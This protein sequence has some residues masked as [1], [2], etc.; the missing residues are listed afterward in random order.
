MGKGSRNRTSRSG[1]VG[2]AGSLWRAAWAYAEVMR[3]LVDQYHP[4][5]MLSPDRTELPGVLITAAITKIADI[6]G[7]TAVTQ[8]RDLADVPII[9][10]ETLLGDYGQLDLLVHISSIGDPRALPAA[11][12]PGDEAWTMLRATMDDLNSGGARAA[13]HDPGHEARIR[14]YNEHTWDP[15]RATAREIILF[16]L[17]YTDG[18]TSQTPAVLGL[19]ARQAAAGM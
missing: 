9:K 11:G 16:A 7:L 2:A 1:E 14:E 10:I 18:V 6:H 19:W 12:D 5:D 15:A 4:Q 8:P 17:T 3:T 13:L